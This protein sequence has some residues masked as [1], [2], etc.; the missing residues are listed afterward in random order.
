MHGVTITTSG[1]YVRGGISTLSRAYVQGVIS[2]L[3]TACTRKCICTRTTCVSKTVVMVSFGSTP[4]WEH[5]KTGTLKPKTW[6]SKCCIHGG[7]KTATKCWIAYGWPM[8]YLIHKLPFSLSPLTVLLPRLTSVPID[9]I[10]HWPNLIFGKWKKK[11][12][13]SNRQIPSGDLSR[14]SE[15]NETDKK[16]HSIKLFCSVFCSE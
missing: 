16:K 4:H 11:K 12:L 1:A 9:Q 10:K 15:E 14:Q 2:V 5:H 8:C 13:T 6:P 7:G 3:A